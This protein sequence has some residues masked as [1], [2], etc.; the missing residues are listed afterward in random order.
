[1]TK[2][3]RLTCLSAFFL[4]TTFFAYAQEEQKKL[5]AEEIVQ[6]AINNNGGAK[7]LDKLHSSEL[8]FL[9]MSD[10]DTMSIAIKRKGFD[11]YLMSRMGT[12]KESSAILFNNGKAIEIKGDMA[13]RITDPSRLEDLSLQCFGLIDYGFKKLNYKLAR[14]D[15][16]RYKIFDCY[17]IQATSPSGRK[18]TVYY[19][20]NS[21]NN[22]MT[23][24]PD[25]NNTVFV[26]YYDKSGIKY[27]A[28]IELTDPRFATSMMLL[29]KIDHN[30]K[31]DAGWFQ[32]PKEGAFISPEKFRSGIFRFVGANSTSTITREKEKQV[33]TDGKATK[34]Y[35]VNWLSGNEYIV[36]EIDNGKDAAIK[37]PIK[38]RITAWDGDKIYCHH[39]NSKNIGRTSVFEKIR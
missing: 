8:M 39:I 35:S 13:S 11:K 20:K 12:N 6:R 17:V 9:Q 34:E 33:E 18:F 4:L 25:G 19:D 26:D 36:T 30:E 1:M 15:D 38:V 3:S 27:P 28:T 22:L 29:Q 14:M 10:K 5:T 24:Y 32:L 31:L 23:K 16:Q 21:G 7:N 2:I 37:E